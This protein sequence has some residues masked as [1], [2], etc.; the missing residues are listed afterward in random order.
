MTDAP[1]EPAHSLGDDQIE[2]LDINGLMS[3]LFGDGSGP[4]PVVEIGS[5]SQEDADAI[6]KLLTD[7][8]MPKICKTCGVDH[9]A[10]MAKRLHRVKTETRYE[11]LLDRIKD[12]LAAILADGA[13]RMLAATVAA[14]MPGYESYY[15][16]ETWEKTVSATLAIAIN[17]T[18]EDINVSLMTESRKAM[19]KDAPE[20]DHK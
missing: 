15:S 9:E 8:M 12:R 20:K 1:R 6:A 11:E 17:A 10:D 5:L 19:A 4:V 16:P 2:D 18:M 13:L 3:A 7:A 14:I